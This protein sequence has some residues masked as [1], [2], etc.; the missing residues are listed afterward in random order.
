MCGPD[1]IQQK[2]TVS[3]LV[4]SMCCGQAAVLTCWLLPQTTTL[5]VCVP[6][7]AVTAIE[8]DGNVVTVTSINGTIFKA[9]YALVTLPLGVLKA[10]SVVFRPPLPPAKQ[11]SIQEMVS[12]HKEIKP[13]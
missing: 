12:V 5:S 6:C 13:W 4:P 9:P 11:A 10:G 2:P 3:R 8:Q 7:T 1:Q